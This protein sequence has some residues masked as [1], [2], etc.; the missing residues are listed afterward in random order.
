MV[1]VLRTPRPLRHSRDGA[2]WVMGVPEGVD[3]QELYVSERIV[4]AGTPATMVFAGMSLLTTA[5][6]A[7]TQL[8][9]MVTPGR[10]MA[11][12]PNQQLAPMMMGRPRSQPSARCRALSTGCSTVMSWQPGP[13][14]VPSPMMMGAMS[15]MTQLKFRKQ[16]SPK[17]VFTPYSRCSGAQISGVAEVGENIWES[18]SVALAGSVLP[19]ALKSRVRAKVAACC[20]LASAE[21]GMYHRPERCVSMLM[22]ARVRVGGAR[23]HKLEEVHGITGGLV[24]GVRAPQPVKRKGRREAKTNLECR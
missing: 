19:S 17:V 21:P 7:M 2:G 4:R 6:A 18:S 10:T 22:V 13:K 24:E 14:R 11:P 20:A 9:P 8:S 3:K 1:S 5:P 15:R 12:A 23:L 16:P